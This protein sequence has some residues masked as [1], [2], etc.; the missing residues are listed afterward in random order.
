MRARVR[1]HACNIMCLASACA[2][3]ARVKY[4]MGV[5]ACNVAKQEARRNEDGE[6]LP[7]RTIAV[8]HDHPAWHR[9][10]RNVPEERETR[11]QKGA[12]GVVFGGR[13]RDDAAAALLAPSLA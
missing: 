3:F 5:R 12:P 9:R 11:W 1:V 6:R 7:R 8:G 13:G 2:H 10:L 4:S